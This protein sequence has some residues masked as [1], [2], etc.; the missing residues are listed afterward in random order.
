M[1]SRLR[2]N[3]SVEAAATPSPVIAAPSKRW[4]KGDKKNTLCFAPDFQLL[5][6]YT[7]ILRA[8]SLL[9]FFDDKEMKKTTNHRVR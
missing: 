5:R 1:D 3:D 4:K 8:F 9:R 7:Q 2:G 6:G